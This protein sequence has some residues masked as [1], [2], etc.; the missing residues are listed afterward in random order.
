MVTNYNFLGNQVITF[1]LKLFTLFFYP[2]ASNKLI[3]VGQKLLKY[4]L[5][6]FGFFFANN[7]STVL[8]FNWPVAAWTSFHKYH[9][10]IDSVAPERW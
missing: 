6:F 5:G 1:N 4:N 7:G 9:M 2:S 8:N 10:G 3:C